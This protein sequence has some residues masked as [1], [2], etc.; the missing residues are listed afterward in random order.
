MPVLVE[1]VTVKDLLSIRDLLGWE[2]EGHLQYAS[3]G[4]AASCTM[5]C[6]MWSVVLTSASP[7]I[8]D[9]ESIARCMLVDTLALLENA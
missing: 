2:A 4:L 6:L 5:V 7:G 8:E 3:P 1:A 9:A